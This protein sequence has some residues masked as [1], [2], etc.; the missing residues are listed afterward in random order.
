MADVG[1]AAPQC[2]RVDPPARPTC[3]GAADGRGDGD[4]GLRARRMLAVWRWT[5]AVTFNGIPGVPH[6][7]RG[8]VIENQIGSPSHGNVDLLRDHRSDCF[9]RFGIAER[10]EGARLDAG[11]SA[12]GGGNVASWRWLV[13]QVSRFA[14]RRSPYEAISAHSGSLPWAQG[15]RSET[16]S[17]VT[18]PILRLDH[19]PRDRQIGRTTIVGYNLE[20]HRYGAGRLLPG[21][22]TGHPIC[23]GRAERRREQ[24][25]FP[26]AAV[27]DIEKGGSKSVFV[28][29]G[30]AELPGWS[31]RNMWWI[32]ENANG[33]FAARGVHG[34]TIYID[35]KA[36]MV[37]V[38][39]ASH[40]FAA[41]SANGS[42]SL[43]AYAAVADYLMRK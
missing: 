13:L 6:A 31:Y 37:L 23:R 10:P 9:A 5:R 29:S 42:I 16:R 27:D 19:F 26:A 1:L 7:P 18:M 2:R 22:Q 40:P 11:F 14:V 33:A 38:R 24:Q 15:S 35:P 34:Q 20:P 25:I 17:M 39:F 12:S 28:E 41:N 32:T 21:G 4:A 8:E 36:E 3:D 30:H 43:P